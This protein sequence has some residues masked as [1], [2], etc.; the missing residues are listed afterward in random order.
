[1]N[2][3]M[4]WNSLE[5][6]RGESADLLPLLAAAE[7]PA[8][9]MR[10][11]VT[12]SECDKIIQ[13]LIDAG[14]LYDPQKPVPPRFLEKSIPENYFRKGDDDGE[15]DDLFIP[16]STPRRRIDVGTSLGYRGNDPAVFFEHAKQTRA[17]FSRLFEPGPET[18]SV[19]PVAAIYDNL[20]RVA[21]EKRVRVAS[22]PDGREYGPAIFRAHY[23]DYTYAPHFDS[24]RLREA[25]EKYTVYRFQ[26][27]FAGV[28][29]LQ[30]AV[31][32]HATAQCVIHQCLWDESIDTELAKGNFHDYARQN[33]VNQC[34]VN[35]EPGDLY[36]FNTLCI[37]EVPGVAGRLPRIVL[38]TF[39]GYSADDPEV[40]VW[41]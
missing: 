40:M 7:T 19:N 35:L 15:G 38:A 31:A 4:S 5:V 3:A 30:N 32:E 28:L 14:E 8:I 18:A 16:E 26:H 29:V 20:Q 21:G 11:A 13:K 6:P 22:E 34:C 36:F 2:E 41:S 24:V 10:G 17:L 12:L 25:R 9:V 1:M 39:I 33:D 27:Q 37:H 23:G